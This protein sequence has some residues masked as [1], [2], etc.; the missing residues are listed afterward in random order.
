MDSPTMTAAVQ[1]LVTL[2][3]TGVIG[4]DFVGGSGS[5][6]GE[7]GFHGKYAMYMDGTWRPTRT[8]TPTSPGYTTEPIPA[9]PVD[10]FRWSVA[11]DLSC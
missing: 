10:R 2:E 8:S 5:I 6:S 7:T 9:G 3:S 11:K 1:Q 4:S